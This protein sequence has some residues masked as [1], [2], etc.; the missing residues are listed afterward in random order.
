MLRDVIT[1]L[2]FECSRIARLNLSIF[3]HIYHFRRGRF[4]LRLLC[5]QVQSPEGITFDAVKHWSFTCFVNNLQVW[6][7]SL[8]AKDAAEGLPR[9]SLNALKKGIRLA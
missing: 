7:V 8:Q 9:S 5:G 4:Y 3:E 1:S 2:V 6:Q